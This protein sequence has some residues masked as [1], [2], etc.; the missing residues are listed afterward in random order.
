VSASVAARP[1]PSASPS[2]WLA[3]LGALLGAAVLVPPL[4]PLARTSETMNALQFAV[5]ALAVPAL[6]VLGAP[7]RHL[8]PL[9]RLAD[10]RAA[11][12]RPSTGLAA[13]VVQVG[14]VVAWRMPVLVS[15]VER[16]RWLL[17]VEAVTLLV[18]GIALWLELVTSPPMRPGTSPSRRIVLAAIAMWA[19]WIV[20]YVLGMAHGQGYSG[21]THNPGHG[22][23][24]VADKQLATAVLWV[25]AAG[26]Y[27]PVVFSNLFAWL[28]AEERAGAGNAAWRLRPER[29][30][31]V[32]EVGTAH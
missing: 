28:R 23:S 30:A 6:V 31:A 10:A 14:L 24:G 1:A 20:A 5:L 8:G 18:A 11:R 17:V 9:T 32:D 26:A 12:A 21:F 4:N 2:R 15:A 29:A 3:A 13:L 16:R 22:L 7:W 25:A 19:V 27:L